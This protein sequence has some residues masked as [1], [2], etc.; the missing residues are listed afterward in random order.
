MRMMKNYEVDDDPVDNLVLKRNVKNRRYEPQPKK[1]NPTQDLTVDNIFLK[2]SRFHKEGEVV[3][4]FKVF[5]SILERLTALEEA[6]QYMPGSGLA[7]QAKASFEIHK[8]L[9]L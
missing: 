7:D 6:I 8:E 2:E 1:L 4:N 3:I 9:L 5:K